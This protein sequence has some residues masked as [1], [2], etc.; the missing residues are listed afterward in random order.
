MTLTV[1]ELKELVNNRVYN[2]FEI[3]HQTPVLEVN[4]GCSTHSYFDIMFKKGS[5]EYM[6]CIKPYWFDTDK[7]D[8]EKIHIIIC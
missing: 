6:V 5:Q 3:I 2:G 7:Y 1:K 8:A 4:M